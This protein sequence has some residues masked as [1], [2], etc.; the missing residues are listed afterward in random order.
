MVAAMDREMFGSC[1]NIGECEAVCPKE[2]SMEFIALMNRDLLK[3]ILM[4]LAPSNGKF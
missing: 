4:G 2:I 3:G 1:T